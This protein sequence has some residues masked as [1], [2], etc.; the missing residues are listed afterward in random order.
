VAASGAAAGAT[1]AV[2][3][4]P[5]GKDWITVHRLPDAPGAKPG[6]TSGRHLLR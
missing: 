2:V 1:I 6:A 4:C 5:T 3:A